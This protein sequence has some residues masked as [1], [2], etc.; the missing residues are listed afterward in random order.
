AGIVD[1]GRV[2]LRHGLTYREAGGLDEGV[3]HAERTARDA[4]VIRV[5]KAADERACSV[6]SSSR[7][8]VDGRARGVAGAD[9]TTR[10]PREGRIEVGADHA[11]L[12]RGARIDVEVFTGTSGVVVA[13]LVVTASRGASG[14]VVHAVGAERGFNAQVAAQLDT[15]VSARDVVEPG[16]VQGAD[17][18]VFDRFGLDGKVGSLCSAHCDETSRGA[19]D[20]AL[21]HL[22][23]KPP[24][25]YKGKVPDPLG[26]DT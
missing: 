11:V 10:G 7:A 9:V 14:R 12:G 20:K 17:L 6:E 26:C 4:A 1:P 3:V 19:E 25:C 5:R 21:N 13:Q 22:H 15:G 23:V 16:A 18:H 2:E 8:G 24:S